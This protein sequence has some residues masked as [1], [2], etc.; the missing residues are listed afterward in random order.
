MQA[1]I[2]GDLSNRNNAA[3]FKSSSLWA[4][5]IQFVSMCV[6]D[7]LTAG[8]TECNTNEHFVSTLT[9][10]YIR[11]NCLILNLWQQEVWTD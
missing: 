7:V 8:E 5:S 6:L 9:V 1:P 11:I 10:S 2:N 3:P 4:A